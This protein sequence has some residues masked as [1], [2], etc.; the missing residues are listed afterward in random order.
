MNLSR[1]VNMK[2]WSFIEKRHNTIEKT[3]YE[4]CRKMKI[5]P[6]ITSYNQI[7]SEETEDYLKEKIK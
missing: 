3:D 5:D 1:V 7:N 2:N 4:F 6:Y